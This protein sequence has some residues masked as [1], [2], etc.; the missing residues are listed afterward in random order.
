MGLES[1]VNR[2][3][4]TG[5]EHGS[6]PHHPQLDALERYAKDNGAHIMV[7][8]IQGQHR[9][10]PLHERFHDYD[11][12]TDEKRRI[13]PKLEIRDF[14]VKAQQIRPLTGLRRHG[15]TNLSYII[16][17]PKQELEFAANS[18]KGM[19]KAIM[20]T[21]VAT[22]P[23]YKHNRIGMIGKEDHVQGAIVV[24]VD[25]DN[26]YHFRQLQSSSNGSFIDLGKLYT[27]KGKCKQVGA[28]T[29]ILGDLHCWQRDPVAYRCALEQIKY[30]K[31]KNVVL[32]D[33]FDAFSITHHDIGRHL[34]RGQKGMKGMLSLRAELEDLSEVLREICATTGKGTVYVVKSN[35]DEAL[36]IYLDSG[37]F[38]GNPDHL[39]L[40]VQLAHDYI[41][42]DDPVKRGV[43][44][45]GGNL[46]KNIKFLQRDDEFKRYGFNLWFHGDKGPNGSRGSLP[47]LEYSLGKGFVG[48]AHTAGK[49]RQ[50][51]RVGTLQHMNPDYAKGSPSAWTHTNGVIYNNSKAQLIN[52]VNGRWKS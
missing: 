5:A 31:P 40:T 25:D 30:L 17:S 42:G 23:N 20:S 34:Y 47:S 38:I 12:V 48:H 15:Q 36:N 44:I 3:I 41:C 6:L 26:N 39:E 11:L 1:L 14:N 50:M 52:T 19:P 46:P 51:W 8:P 7:I 13:H 32:H 33:V 24:E 35:H 18:V 9:D 27:P 21:G 10:M 22:R 45:V 29:L 4:I 49:F 2:Y 16:G 28:D 37:R 43:E